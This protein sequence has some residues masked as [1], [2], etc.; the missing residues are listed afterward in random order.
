MTYGAA[1]FPQHAKLLANSA[2]SPEVARARGYVS[3]D[4]KKRLENLGF[5]RYQRSVPGLLI[6]AHRADGSIWGYQCRPDHPRVTKAGTVI[7]YETPK[8]QRNGI[9]IPP[10]ARDQI[11]D[12]SVPLLVTEGSRKADAAVSAGL[13]CV[14]LNGVYGWRGRNGR[15]GRLAVADWHDIALNGRRLVLAFDSDVVRKRMVHQA[16]AQLAGY[17][18]SKG[19]AAE[20]LHLPDDGGAK[21]GLDDYIAE[22]GTGGLWGLV[23]PELPAVQ[24]PLTPV[25]ASSGDSNISGTPPARPVPV[26]PP[27]TMAQVEAVYS[28]WLHDGDGVTTRVCHAA[29][30]ANMVLVGDPVWVLLVGGSGQGKTERL[31]PLADMPHVELASTL[32]G[33]AALLS[34]T[35]RRDRAEHA[36][37]GL[38]RRIGDKGILIVKDFTSILEMDRTARGQVLAALREVYDGRW[39]REVGTEGGQTLTWR[40]K[41]GLLAACT[42]TIDKA[43]TVMNDMGPRS[44]FVRLPPA[45]PAE[46]GASAL[47]H[48]GRETTMRAELAAATA[49]LLTHL[50]GNPHDTEPVRDGLIGL[51]ALVSLARSP[52]HRDWGGEVELVGDPEAPTRIIKQLG[53]LWRACGVLG[54]ARPESWEVVQRCALDSI[55]KL[56][57]AVIRYL[58]DQEEPADTTT[59]RIALAHPKRTVLRALEDLT[60]HR[61]ISRISTGQGHADQWTLSDQARSWTTSTQGVPKMLESLR[62]GDC[63]I[64]GEPLDQSYIDAGFTNH[65]EDPA[66]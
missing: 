50:P 63:T 34:A 21:T 1:I 6:P 29:Y 38:L 52:V 35:A 19:A 33:E 48:M 61:V 44:L 9:D 53:Q 16:L 46:I 55:P 51:A 18:I 27:M 14:S 11:S 37:G 60:A 58:T 40:G 5:E 12:P 57:G 15:G 43:H 20:Y 3:V 2:I 59:I 7:K 8:D 45:D 23:R 47:A 42:T 66:A 28:R 25:T 49:G 4:I 64:C 31:A 39:D 17:L 62:A 26:A 65:G 56:R 32:S 24:M 10:G 41:C 36:H 54:L 22:H 13:V 30:V